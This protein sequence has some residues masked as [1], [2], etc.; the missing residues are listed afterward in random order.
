[1]DE[2]GTF[3]RLRNEFSKLLGQKGIDGVLE[4]LISTFATKRSLDESFGMEQELHLR[5]KEA[6]MKSDNS[7]RTTVR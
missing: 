4:M 1:M 7:R 3:Q 2:F 6:S 5:A